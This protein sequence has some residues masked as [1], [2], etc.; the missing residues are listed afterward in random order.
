MN[1]FST[2]LKAYRN[3]VFIVQI[4]FINPYQGIVPLPAGFKMEMLIGQPANA[5]NPFSTPPAGA[6]QWWYN[7]GGSVAL[8][9]N[10]VSIY[11]PDNAIPAT[12]PANSPWNMKSF[13]TIISYAVSTTQGFANGNALF[14]FPALVTSGLVINTPYNWMVLSQVPAMD[15]SAVCGGPLIAVDAPAIQ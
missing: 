13:G 3:Q 10:D 1:S 6:P 14:M 8:G 11:P 9:E 15:P 5:A 7:P 12:L 4:S 2:P